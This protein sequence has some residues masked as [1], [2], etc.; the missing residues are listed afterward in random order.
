MESHVI[1]KYIPLDKS[2]IIRMG[3]LDL[4]NGY[5][6]TITFLKQQKNLSDDLQALYRASIAWP[7]NRA[8]DVGESG[9]LYRFLR[10]AA[11]KLN[12]D[13]EFI[14][15]GTLRER[16]MTNDPAIVEYSL[17]DLLQLDS[18]TSQWA[19]AAVLTGVKEKI[20]Y[21]PFKLRLTYDAVE[22][23]QQA[24][25]KKQ[26]WQ[27]R[28]DQTILR[29]AEAYINLLHHRTT[30]YE[31]LQAEDY[32]FA[33]AFDF[34]APETGEA[35]WPSLRSHESDRIAAMEAVLAMDE[36]DRL[37]VNDH[38]VVQAYAIRQ[39]VLGKTVRV[40]NPTAVNKSWPQFWNFINYSQSLNGS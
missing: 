17:R 32:C 33:R 4:L 2:W 7:E 23:W 9:T 36:N 11:W 12:R 40:E 34:I 8:V 6:D 37:A 14:V 27:P 5:D 18:G 3:V 21:A 16:T 29:Q 31:P 15:H 38:R 30:G 24:R 35:S 26:Q 28:Y 20:A 10:F 1:K 22:H 25:Q 39:N 19:S 13:N